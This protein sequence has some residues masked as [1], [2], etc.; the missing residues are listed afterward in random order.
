MTAYPQLACGAANL[1]HL[2]YGECNAVPGLGG[3]DGN[4]QHGGNGAMKADYSVQCCWVGLMVLSPASWLP[5]LVFRTGQSL[6]GPCC[7][8]C[9]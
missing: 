4:P 1:L 2:R 8:Y 3:Q 5:L 7:S 9:S 6:S